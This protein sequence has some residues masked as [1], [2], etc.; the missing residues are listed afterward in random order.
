MLDGVELHFSDTLEV[1]L[2]VWYHPDQP[3]ILKLFN[4][5]STTING[6]CL[7]FSACRARNNFVNGGL[8]IPELEW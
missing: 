3:L 6:I 7:T 4:D 8:P 2:Q 5:S 1:V